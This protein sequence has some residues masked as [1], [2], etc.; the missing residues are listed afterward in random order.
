MICVW[1][2]ILLLRDLI[3]QNGFRL[4]LLLLLLLLF[5]G[6]KFPAFPQS[7]KHVQPKHVARWWVF[8][9]A[10][11]FN[12]FLAQ[13]LNLFFP[14][15]EPERRSDLLPCCGS[16]K[17]ALFPVSCETAP[18]RLTSPFKPLTR[19]PTPLKS[20]P[21]SPTPTQTNE[22]QSRPINK[23]PRVRENK[24]DAATADP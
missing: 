16:E 14:Q 11:G 17:N 19:P 7:H 18:P 21:P 15:E 2:L 1:V 5:Y 9:T 6:S 23:P 8:F 3:L 12:I 13:N 10:S 24:R 22:E 20:R 4:S